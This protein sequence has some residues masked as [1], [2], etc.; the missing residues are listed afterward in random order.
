MGG[1]QTMESVRESLD[2]EVI[3]IV[4]EVS[5]QEKPKKKRKRHVFTEYEDG[6]LMKVLERR[7]GERLRKIRWKY[8][9]G[10]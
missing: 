2:T 1:H 7:P 6:L 9:N 4:P 10:Q 8:L 3:E 5:T